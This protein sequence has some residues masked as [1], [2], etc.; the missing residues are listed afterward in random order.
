MANQQQKIG[1]ARPSTGFSKGFLLAKP[2][3]SKPKPSASASAAEKPTK[4][5]A[6]AAAAA[7]APKE[8]NTTMKRGFLLS[9]SKP[10]KKSQSKDSSLPSSATGETLTTDTTTCSKDGAV[11]EPKN[12]I[13]VHMQEELPAITS[14]EESAKPTAS[15]SALLDLEDTPKNTKKSCLLFV[16]DDANTQQSSTPNILVEDDKNEDDIT[17]HQHKNALGMTEVSSSTKIQSN[18]KMT[19]ISE[20]E[21]NNNSQST[22][23]SHDKIMERGNS[24]SRIREHPL[25][26]GE[27][28]KANRAGIL[29]DAEQPTSMTSLAQTDFMQCQQDLDRALWNIRRKRK[30]AEGDWRTI[31]SEFCNRLKPEEE[32]WAWIWECL[33]CMCPKESSQNLAERRLGCVMLECISTKSHWEVLA[34][35]LIPDESKTK[36]S[37]LLTLGAI[38]VLDSWASACQEKKPSLSIDWTASLLANVMPPLAEQVTNQSVRTLLAQRAAKTIYKTIVVATEQSAIQ[39][40]HNRDASLLQQEI[41]NICSTY[42]IP[43]WNMQMNWNSA[44]EQP[45]EDAVEGRRAIARSNCSF[46]VLE[47][48]KHSLHRIAQSQ[49]GAPQEWCKVILGINMSE[50]GTMSSSGF[51]SLQQ[52]LFNAKHKWTV[53]DVVAHLK[54]A[55]KK[56]QG[57]KLEEAAWLQQAIARGALAWMGQS[58]QNFSWILDSR[59]RPAM[60][61]GGVSIYQEIYELS[62]QML[63]YALTGGVVKLTLEILYVVLFLYAYRWYCAEIFYDE[64]S[65]LHSFPLFLAETVCGQMLTVFQTILSFSATSI[66]NLIINKE[67]IKPKDPLAWTFL[68]RSIN[69]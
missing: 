2:N 36:E 12:D 14:A 46:V 10:A 62:N 21:P 33:F 18:E 7:P 34:R 45:D 24:V 52:T 47:D 31:A 40:D 43:V 17:Q 9:K 1:K 26:G 13:R 11:S 22:R 3:K 19:P 57:G 15:S 6:A 50:N 30:S 59:Y 68:D 55:I 39:A 44:K 58:K 16:A 28:D 49:D 65:R 63:R 51:G 61:Q 8:N 60:R 67:R 27:S 48:W 37:R 29:Q 20:Y 56:P 5:S 32:L 66:V 42:L 64:V 41:W 35:F 54:L 4:T 38:T 23:S 53:E 25:G 69:G